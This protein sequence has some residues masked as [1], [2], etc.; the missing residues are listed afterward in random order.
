M[1]V[2]L[3]VAIGDNGVIGYQG[4]MPW[5][6]TGDQVQF[7]Q[8]TMGHPMI[9]GRATFESIGRPLP[10]RTSIVLTRDPQWS[11]EGVEVA[12][13]LEHAL[14]IAAELDD[15]VFIIG[16]AQVYAAAIQ[17]GVVDRMVITHVRLSP[18]GDA[19]FPEVD[20]SQWAETSRERYDGY[21]IADYVA[22][23]SSTTGI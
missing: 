11:A 5:P 19:W 20:W 9:M 7:K 14:A 4:D 23:G 1:T 13:D 15:E 16:G 17:A 3:V 10:G 22:K 21:D 6:R 18:Q 8:A 2:A 12:G